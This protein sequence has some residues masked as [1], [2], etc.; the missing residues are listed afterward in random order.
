VGIALLYST[1][2][3][4]PPPARAEYKEAPPLQKFTEDELKIAVHR[5]PNRKS[6]GPDEIPNKVVKLMASKSP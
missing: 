3:E 1:I 5:M 6:P 2:V 4:H